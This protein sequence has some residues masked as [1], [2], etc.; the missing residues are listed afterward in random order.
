MSLLRP[1]LAA[2][3]TIAAAVT[4]RAQVS[5]PT[6]PAPTPAAA[7]LMEDLPVTLATGT[8]GV[9]IPL[10]SV[11]G[12]TLS[13][14]ITIS[15]HGSAV[16][17]TDAASWVG[18]GWTLSAGGAITRSIRGKP[19]DGSGGYYGGTVMTLYNNTSL[20]PA[21]LNDPAFKVNPF[22]PLN[23]S[24]LAAIE[25][26]QYDLEP[27]VF[28]YSVPGR[29]GTF[30]ADPR[31]NTFFTVPASDVR[32][33]VTA[34]GTSP[35]PAIVSSPSPF[36]SWTIT[37]EDGTAYSFGKDGSNLWY[38]R[39]EA[40][41]VT[42]IS[43][44]HLNRIASPSGADAVTLAYTTTDRVIE[45]HGPTV[46][47]EVKLVGNPVSPVCPSLGVSSH[48]SPTI[49][50][51]TR[52]LLAIRSD[53]QEATFTM[54]DRDDLNKEIG[55][56]GVK[57]GVRLSRIDLGVRTGTT[58]TFSP[59]RSVRFT[60]NYFDGASSQTLLHAGLDNPDQGKRLKLVSVQEFAGDNSV[61]LPPHTFDYFA[62]TLLSRYNPNIDYWGF[63]RGGTA[64][65][66]YLPSYT[67]QS[68]ALD[69]ITGVNRSP[70]A[71]AAPLLPGALRSVTYPSGGKTEIA[72]EPNSYVDPGNQTGGSGGN[73]VTQSRSVW[74][75]SDDP[76]RTA[77]YYTLTN[78][79]PSPFTTGTIPSG[80]NVPPP[81]LS[82]SSNLRYGP[83]EC[84]PLGPCLFV[85]VRD[86]ATN[87]VVHQAN[88]SV[89]FQS[90]LQSALQS[91]KSYVL[92]A[93]LARRNVA[94]ECP[95]LSCSSPFTVGIQW[96]ESVPPSTVPPN[97]TVGGGLRVSTLTQSS[98]VGSTTAGPSPN[99]VR[100]FTYT[101]DAGHTTGRVEA[102]PRFIF[103]R[104]VAT[105][106]FFAAQTSS[107]RVPL[108]LNG[109][110]SVWYQTVRERITG[111]DG[112]A[113]GTTVHQFT[114]PYLEPPYYYST[115]QGAPMDTPFDGQTRSSWANGH[116]TSSMA[117][118]ATNAQVR[119]QTTTYRRYDYMGTGDPLFNASK[120][121]RIIGMQREVYPS[122]NADGSVWY[123]GWYEIVAAPV[124]PAQQVTRSWQ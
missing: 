10:L 79:T 50:H 7:A 19:D 88:S 117:L 51:H 106:C 4:V 20:A 6:P 68:V 45:E 101:S 112:S 124:A 2:L 81:T 74:T 11:Q 13:V 44:W 34:R 108:G 86:A 85:T 87:A 65:S 75:V 70:S 84:L 113:A 59:D 61:S 41:G 21:T 36:L 97:V 110:G 49:R 66:G 42:N 47:R 80:S 60:H 77:D 76:A 96:T 43:T 58:G 56:A 102:V 55:S 27:D 28:F 104:G 114:M 15:H 25:G 71:T 39:T 37:L 48:H 26:G 53:F 118:S 92:E 64:N 105:G 78:T 22:A 31:T 54:S 40:A 9:Q 95:M 82:V 120:Y 23:T 69:G 63:P 103:P 62:G 73:T 119:E 89:P 8:V 72:Y 99:R 116:P 109:L 16:R 33:E 52:D 83:S 57:Q 100:T 18:L 14:P 38:D 1:L 17:P 115:G 123:Y 91:N 94:G 35:A 67:G 30:Y 3:V 93:K 122:T 90:A 24:A 107:A 111:A 121:R 12:R 98:G 5:V 29:S 32:I 46:Q